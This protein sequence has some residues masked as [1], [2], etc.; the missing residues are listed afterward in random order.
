[1]QLVVDVSEGRG[2]RLVGGPKVF[3]GVSWSG[4]Q[5]CDLGLIDGLGNHGMAAQELVAA[6]ILVDCTPVRDPLESLGGGS[7]GPAAD[8]MGLSRDKGEIRDCPMVAGL[9]CRIGPRCR[10]RA[11]RPLRAGPPKMGPADVY[12]TPPGKANPRFGTHLRGN[13][14]KWK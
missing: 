2:S 1:M 3:S 10:T 9:P 12:R 11:C 8:P 4:A 13:C 5:A 6:E 7:L 14:H